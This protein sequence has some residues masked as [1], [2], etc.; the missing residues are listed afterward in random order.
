MNKVNV[1]N[2]AELLEPFL[3]SRTGVA[4]RASDMRPARC[5]STWPLWYAHYSATG[6]RLSYRP[7]RVFLFFPFFFFF[8]F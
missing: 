8:F 4:G 6:Y 5:A 7:W 1:G 3:C 2:L